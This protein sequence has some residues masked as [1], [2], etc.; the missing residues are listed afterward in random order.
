MPD[1]QNVLIFLTDGHRADCLGCYGNPLLKTPNVDRMARQ[2]IRFDRSYAAHTV[3][4]PT[5]RRQHP[6]A[7]V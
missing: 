4:M 3:C 1:R 5:R 7:H 6:S 2:G